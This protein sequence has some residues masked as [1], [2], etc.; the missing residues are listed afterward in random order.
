MKLTF[1]HDEDRGTIE[2]Y[3]DGIYLGDLSASEAEDLYCELA[4]IVE[5]L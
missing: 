2:V 4:D 5:S 3:K 1:K